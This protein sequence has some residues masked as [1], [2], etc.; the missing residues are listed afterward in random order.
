MSTARVVETDLGDE[1]VLLNI[2]TRNMFTLNTSGRTIW[3]GY[4]SGGLEA[5]VAE[6]VAQF[7]VSPAQARRDALVLLREL[8]TQGLL[9]AQGLLDRLSPDDG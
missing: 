9:D 5:A 4:R 6:L 1:L 7:E 3:R 8:Q 2:A